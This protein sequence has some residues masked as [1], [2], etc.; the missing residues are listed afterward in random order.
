M[1]D[2]IDSFGIF[3]PKTGRKG[4]IMEMERKEPKLIED[5]ERPIYLD[6]WGNE[7]ECYRTD[8]FVHLSQFCDRMESWLR[9]ID[10]RKYQDHVRIGGAIV[11]DWQKE[12][13]ALGDVVEEK[14]GKID[15]D[16]PIHLEKSRR[17][18]MPAGV[19]LESAQK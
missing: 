11:R 9:M 15:I 7:L 19:K 1:I 14:I 13:F 3:L 18:G 17:D 6:E 8:L 10:D 2:R 5:G 12:I 4:R 16:F